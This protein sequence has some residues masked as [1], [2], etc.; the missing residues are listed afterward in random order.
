[1][2]GRVGNGGSST[3][4][5][6]RTNSDL[7]NFCFPPCVL[8]TIL[9]RPYVRIYFAPVRAR[10]GSALGLKQFSVLTASLL[11]CFST[12]SAQVHVR[13]RERI[14]KRGLPIVFE[15]APA[16]RAMTARIAGSTVAF[17]PAAV[18]VYA[19]KQ[20]RALEIRFDGAGLSVPRGA[21]LQKSQTNYLVGNNPAEWRTHV[22]NYGKV[23]YSDLYPGVDAVFYGKGDHLEHDFIV[24]PGADYR[25]IRMR[26]PRGAR[27]H[28]GKDG[29]LTAAVAG[30]LL[31]MQ[32]PL[33]YQE[34]NGG[35]QKRQGAFRML[36]D[37][38]VG[39]EVASY[40]PRA[41]LIIDPVLDFSTYLSQYSVG[42]VAIV[43]DASG[44]SYVAGYGTVG[45]PVTSGAFAGCS[46]CAANTTYVFTSISK[47]SADGT[48][49]VYSTLLGGNALAQPTGIAVDANGDAIVSGWTA[50][51]DFPTKSGQPILTPN[52]NNVGYL[53]SLSLDGSSLN[54]GTLLSVSPTAQ[55]NAMTYAGPVAV[56]AAGNA[57]VTGTTGPGFF[58]S[59]GALNQVAAGSIS[60]ISDV[61]L[62]KF[63]PTGTL[64]YSALL[65]TADP[66]NGGGGPIGPTA[67]AVD[68]AGDAY[69]AGQA[70]TVWP[71]TS[72]AYLNQIAGTNPYAA[73]FVMKVAPD[74]K[75]VVYSTY[76]DYAYKVAGISILANGNL[77]VTGNGA[78]ATYPTTSDAY[79]ANSG[80]GTAFLTELNA[81]GSALVYSTMVCGGDC[82]VN[83]MSVDSKGNIWLAEQTSNPKF[84]LLN[85]L[86]STIPN[87]VT[88]LGPVSAVSEF[89]PAGKT[90]EF[91]TF[92]GG[93]AAGHASSVAVDPNLRAHIAGFAAYGMY[94]TAG[95]YSGS[96]PFPGQSYLGNTYGYVALIDPTVPA[97]A[98]CIVP[99]SQ[100]TL[101]APLGGSKDWQYTVKSC[102]ADS[103]TITGIST[104]A[105]EFSVPDSG[106]GCLQTLA[107]GQSCTFSL[108]FAPTVAGE[109]TATL[110][111]ASNSPVPVVL[112]LV[113]NGLTSPQISLSATSLT[114]GPQVV[115][116]Q[117]APQTIT[118]TNT[119]N[120]TLS[121]IGFG[122]M[123]ADEPIWPLTFTCGPSLAP[124]DSCT[125]SVSFKPVSTGTTTATLIVENYS[126]L[127]FQQVTLTGTS[128]LSP[129]GI[130]TQAGGSMS[131][132]VT[133]GSTA[134]YALSV[135]PAAGYSNTV[136][137]SCANLP[138]NASCSFN[139]QSL[140]VSGGAAVNFTISVATES[141]QTAGAIRKAGFGVVLAGLIFLLPLRRNR[142]R[143]LV[144]TYVGAVLLVTSISACGGSSSAS[145]S[146]QAAKVSPGTYSISV[147]ASD[148]SGNKSTQN[149][150]L[151]VQ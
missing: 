134:K 67:I 103:L 100:L 114:F 47:L 95:A 96:L 12:L 122:M 69:V 123:A 110:T 149:L 85:P 91:A 21:D 120:A 37:G 13:S 80:N 88:S 128:P 28:V 102:G 42:A 45:Y 124:G 56:D 140:T 50:A 24:K 62:A 25:Q 3:D 19:G 143:M 60:N 70:G 77:F 105:G 90:L 35:R 76:L 137:L 150:T 30:N 84:P 135:T 138:A 65:G 117:S 126:N 6:R 57:Y 115:G 26:F 64:L 141:F 44:D 83:G 61:F 40:D 144:M 146:S 43:S 151:I 29:T 98:L 51:T 79:E 63:D 53:V 132:T 54:Y 121:G 112:S 130:G 113:G 101:N 2:T 75:S 23:L 86:Q 20:S 9:G 93:T 5:L 74:A 11:V 36:P 31:Q 7:E 118:L 116:T 1:M 148:T 48:Q 72:G 82:Q 22:P 27:I 109:Q 99:N 71:I 73:P 133:A 58:I 119:G 147:T 139:P 49:L 39:F 46:G 34:E 81:S 104:S 16:R 106:N 17:Q 4:A 111:I 87:S 14:L 68:S 94:T 131:S 59:S 78:S 10:W 127:P 145:S 125:F 142:K 52:N 107:A 66:Q 32:A 92:L 33:V 8:G 15:P 38:D 136:N 55:M 41:Y 97:A 89:D 129:F 18:D 108:H